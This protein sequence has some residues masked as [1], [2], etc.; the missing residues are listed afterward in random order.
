MDYS[1]ENMR[2]INQAL[3][4]L[5]KRA[6]KAKREHLIE[7]FVDIGPLFTLLSNSDNQILYGRRGTGKTHVLSYLSTEISNSN[8]IAVQL[9]MRTI[10]STGGIYSDT[11]LPLSERATRLLVD[12]LC[13]IHEQILNEVINESEE[14]NLAVLGPLLDSFIEASTAAIVDGTKKIDETVSTANTK[15]KKS[16]ASISLQP[17]DFKASASNH[18]EKKFTKQNHISREGQEKLRVH[19]N[20]VGNEL[21]KVVNALPDAELWIILDEWSEIPLDLQPYLA[22]LLRRVVFPVN[23]V[24]VKIAA[25][26]QRCRFRISDDVSGNI[27][28]E[29]GADAAASIDLDEF[30]VF[31]NDT[32]QA[33]LFFQELLF[34]HKQLRCP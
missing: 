23:G 5:S 14:L 19:F 29:I 27:G 18:T 11:R 33:K 4:K 24:S 16:E 10:G 13:E 8:K 1:K 34:K 9:D 28:I 12:V 30:L 3:L 22:D 26:E 25:I 32:E 15:T 2:K 17:K 31:D 20:A 6:E 21:S 7:S